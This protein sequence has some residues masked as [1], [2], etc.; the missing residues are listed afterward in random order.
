MN[1]FSRKNGWWLTALAVLIL[2]GGLRALGQLQSLENATSD[3]RARLLAHEVRSD[4][5]IVGIDAASLQKLNEWPWPR[6]HHAA[7]VDQL[8]RSSP[9]SV[10]LDIDFSSQTNSLDDALLEA[11][12]AKPRD[13]PVSLPTYLDRKSTR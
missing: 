8:R 1:H 10:F 3:M 5:V 13:F 6:R 12:L 11:A 9:A 4:I 2:V 7:L